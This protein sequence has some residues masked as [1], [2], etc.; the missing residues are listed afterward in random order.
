MQLTIKIVSNDQIICDGVFGL[1]W[2]TRAFRLAEKRLDMTTQDILL[3]VD[4]ENVIINLTYC[5]LQNWLQN[6]DE[7]ATLPFSIVNLENWINDQPRE[8]ITAIS[9]DYMNSTLNGKAIS[10]LYEEVNA[11]YA[12]TETTPTKAVKKK[13][14]P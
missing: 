6:K 14:S 12:A 3:N 9:E 5:A 10:D 1:I 7:S 11:I 13:K 4:D 2:G 8:L